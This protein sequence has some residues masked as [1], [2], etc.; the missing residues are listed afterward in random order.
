MTKYFNNFSIIAFLLLSCLAVI[1]VQCSG[2]EEKT[3]LPDTI[4]WRITGNRLEKSSFLFGTVHGIDS[5]DFFLHKTMIEQLKRS[6]MVVFETDLTI[7]DYQQK[8][9]QYAMMKDDSLDRMLTDSQYSLVSGFFM[10]EFQFPIAAVK[11][12]K[13]FYVASL[14]AALRPGEKKISYEEVFMKLAKE[15]EK[16]I[17]GISTL[18]KE[19][20]ILSAVDPDEQVRYLLDE[21]ERYKKGENDSLREEMISAY[22]SADLNR[23]NTLTKNSLSEYESIYEHMFVVR[24]Q[25]WLEEMDRLMSDQ[26]C[27]FAVGVGHLPGAS[28]LI[29]LLRERGYKVVPVK[30]DFWFHD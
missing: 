14:I 24:N 16:E 19:S 10:D 26:R 18:E 11:K 5:S 17:S 8:A 30:M 22:I 29:Q 21:I 1:I 9:F 13:P 6:D 27:F 12:M 3:S 4:I 7:P 2:Q 25:S 28:G 23:I 20:E 15:E